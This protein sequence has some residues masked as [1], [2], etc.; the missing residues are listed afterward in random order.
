MVIRSCQET[1]LQKAYELIQVVIEAVYT[2]YY[3]KE[4]VDFFK[5]YYSLEALESAFEEESLYVVDNQGEVI[6]IGAVKLNEIRRVFIDIRYQ[7][8]GYGKDMVQFLED[9]IDKN[10]YS[11]VILDGSLSGIEFY[12]KM[13]YEEQ[14]FSQVE[15]KQATLC[16]IK[17]RKPLNCHLKYNLN[18]KQFVSKSNTSTGEVSSKTLFTYHQNRNIIWADYSGGEVL[19]GFL[20][21]TMNQQGELDFTYQH[22]NRFGENRNG[23]CHSIPVVLDD[24]RLQ[25]KEYW[26]WMD[27]ET[28]KGESV[29]IEVNS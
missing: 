15:L 1:E 21:G 8:Q 4:A 25:Y 12:K 16:Y 14:G 19:Q 13:G 2:R 23:R 22:I 18:L 28:S 7:G 5:A 11:E 24:G 17:M 29:I 3:H 6:G 27:K 9:L 10:G 20:I 26:Q